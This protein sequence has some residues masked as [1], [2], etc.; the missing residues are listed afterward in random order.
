MSGTWFVRYHSLRPHEIFSPNVSPHPLCFPFQYLYPSVGCFRKTRQN[1]CNFV[2]SSKKD[3]ASATL[4]FLLFYFF[5]F[6]EFS[7][8]S[9]F[10]N[11]SYFHSLK[12][13]C[14][15]V[16]LFCTILPDVLVRISI[17]LKVSRVSLVV[18]IGHLAVLGS[19]IFILGQFFLKDLFEC[20]VNPEILV[21]I[22]DNFSFS[23]CY[24]KI[25]L[26]V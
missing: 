15:F 26:L 22:F 9:I 25:A 6:L 18:L 3:V 11:I 19:D 10:L 14:D 7:S 17:F 12:N 20:G 8:C 24:C 16:S 5:L 21:R 2:D 4:S 23:T 1:F 13:E